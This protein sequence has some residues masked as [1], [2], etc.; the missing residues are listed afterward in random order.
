MGK[1]RI[2]TERRWNISEIFGKGEMASFVNFIESID[3]TKNESKIT[4]ERR[5]DFLEIFFSYYLEHKLRGKGIITIINHGIVVFRGQRATII[6]SE[7]RIFHRWLCQCLRRNR[8]INISFLIF[9]SVTD[10][11]ISSK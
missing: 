9:R 3:D 5:Y 11:T 1:G 6:S 4:K 10:Y 7:Q 2:R 8:Y